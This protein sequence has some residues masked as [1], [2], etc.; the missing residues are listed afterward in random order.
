[1][2]RESSTMGSAN[3]DW[4]SGTI[5]INNLNY[6]QPDKNQQR[7]VLI[8]QRL[9]GG[10]E[11]LKA[12]ESI[13]AM[14]FQETLAVLRVPPIGTACVGAKLLKWH[15]NQHVPVLSHTAAALLPLR[16]SV[17]SHSLIFGKTQ[18]NPSLHFPS[19]LLS[20]LVSLLSCISLRLLQ[21]CSSQL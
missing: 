3:R 11:V 10:V 20:S 16:R 17:S 4:G 6:Q 9:R 13:C 21:C 14:P 15:L 5:Y 12:N 1:M 18:G 7:D 19:S 8:E 2:L